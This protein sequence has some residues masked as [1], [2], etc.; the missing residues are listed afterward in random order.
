LREFCSSDCPMRG[1]ITTAAFVGLCLALACAPVRAEGD[2]PVSVE[3]TGYQ[4]KNGDVLFTIHVDNVSPECQPALLMKGFRLPFGPYQIDDFHEDHK[5][6]TDLCTG[7][8]TVLDISTLDLQNLNTGERTVLP[9]GERVELNPAK[10]TL[11]AR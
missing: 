7:I 1:L 8:I 4:Y 2:C 11:A 6:V 10:K 9:F 5:V 3:F